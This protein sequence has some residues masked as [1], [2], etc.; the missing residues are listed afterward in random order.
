M[1]EEEITQFAKLLVK[2]VRDAAIKSADVQLYAHNMNSPIAKRWRSR[3][4]SGNIDKFAEEVIADC[5]DNTIFYFLLAIDEGLF[6]ASFTASN[7]KDIP[8]ADD[9]IGELGGWYMG[10]WRSEYSEE[11]CSNDLDDI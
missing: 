6:K 1:T 5:V 4:E 2:H 10:E 3:K 9:I 11:R 8:L 7:G